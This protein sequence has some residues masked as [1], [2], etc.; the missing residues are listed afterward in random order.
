[1][2]DPA[3]SV[4]VNEW[5]AAGAAGTDFIELF[6][7]GANPVE[8]RGIYLS[9][10][11]L[12]RSRFAIPPLS[13]IGSTG[14]SRW[15]KWIADN[16]ASGTAEHVNFELSSTGDVVGLFDSGGY[17]IDAVGFGPQQSGRTGGRFPDGASMILVLNPTPGAANQLVP[18][19][20]SDGDGIPDAWELAKGLNPANPYDA[21]LDSDG[22]GQSNLA[23][24]IAGTDPLSSG[25]ALRAQLLTS[26]GSVVIRFTAVAGKT[27]TVQYKND[28]TASQW[29]KLADVPAG[30][31]TAELDVTD[32]GN[33]GEAKRFYRI[34]TPAAP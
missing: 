11:L 29:T 23:E 32:P 22:D 9:D 3:N 15:Q 30:A 10:D 21:L 13:F 34:V 24:Y 12:D 28:L 6:N 26:G 5:S 20:D 4:R 19:G 14:A 7:T 18:G 16:D 1:M 25:D 27:Y 33:A 8:M 17:S 31:L 2:V